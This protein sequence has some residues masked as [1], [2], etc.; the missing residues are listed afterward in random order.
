MSESTVDTGV[1]GGVSVAVDD[2]AVG[3][4]AEYFI[5]GADG[6]FFDAL[7][8][9]SKWLMSSLADFRRTGVV[10]DPGSRNCPVRPL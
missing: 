7:L 2:N 4:E 8:C 10:G 1:T 6:I 9:S 3:D 5:R